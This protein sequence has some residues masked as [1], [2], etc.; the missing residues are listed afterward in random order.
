[1]IKIFLASSSE[2][3]EDR[4]AFDLHFRQANDRLFKKGIYLKIL[5]WETFLDAISETSLQDEYNKEVR[6]CDIFASLF[7]MKT[8]QYTE[9]EF[10][11]AHRAFKDSGKPLIYAYYMETNISNDKR[12][13]ENFMSLWSFQG[14]LS[15]LGHYPTHYTSIEDLLLQFLGQLDKMI[16]ER[17]I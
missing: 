4:D 5:R 12:L 9:E 2:L 1:M 16:E 10:D 3:K 17:K 13:R 15:G 6:N 11:V 8:G 7:Q 14:K